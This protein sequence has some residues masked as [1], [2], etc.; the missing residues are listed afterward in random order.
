MRRSIATNSECLRAPSR[1]L[2]YATSSEVNI[3][4]GTTFTDSWAGGGGGMG[5]VRASSNST[6]T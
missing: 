6:R 3:G 4:G 2:M 5:V 1:N